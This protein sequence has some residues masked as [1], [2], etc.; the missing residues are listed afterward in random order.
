MA[1][2]DLD[3][4]LDV[5]A[6]EAFLTEELGPAE[7]FDAEPLEGGNA[8]ETLLVA[9]GDTEYVLRRPP[10]DEPAPELLHDLLGEYEVLDALAETW[11]PTPEVYAA[12]ADESVLGE[13]FYVM[14]TVEGDII[15]DDPPERFET[16]GYR[17]RI[18]TEVVDT[19]AKL[20][21][22]DPERVGLAEFGDPA[23]FAARQVEV[24][25]DQLDWAQERT[26]DARELPQ[27][28]AVGDW[29]AGNAPET[30]QHTLVH[31]DYKPDNLMFAAGT[32]PE[33]T[34]VLDWEMAS[35]GDPLT[36]LGWILSY[37]TEADDPSPVSDEIEEKYADHDYYPMLRIFVDDYSRFMTHGDYHSRS[38]LVERYERET[39][40]E[41]TDDRFYRALGVYKLAALCEGFYRMYLEDSPSVKE[42]YP[43]M[44]M[45]VPTL[46]EQARLIIDGET[47][48]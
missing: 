4:L 20:H 10:V 19:L 13:Q 36:D 6:L 7:E 48:L 23:D 17:H 8:N 18:G 38:E 30:R 41:Y 42:S 34:A 40:F 25:T 33:I 32:P 15:E 22:V 39:G 28:R 14:E 35:L 24:L 9:W 12:C 11:V 43:L 44:E 27:L 37:W 16:T 5:D 1:T 45:M 3:H 26:A 46:A 31:G 47:P 21:N 2:Q 29:L